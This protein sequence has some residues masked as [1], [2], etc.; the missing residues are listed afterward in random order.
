MTATVASVS[1]DS[2]SF[3][4][5]HS[6]RRRAI[7]ATAAASSRSTTI[8]ARADHGHDPV[9][10]RLVE[11]DAAELIHRLRTA[12]LIE[13]VL[14]PPQDRRFEGAAAKVVDGDHGPCRHALLTGVLN[15]G[16]LRLAQ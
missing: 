6:S 16:R 5:R 7:A 14:G 1:N 4:R 12:K 9:E 2:A 11:V 13:A 15:G 3:A 10:N 8:A